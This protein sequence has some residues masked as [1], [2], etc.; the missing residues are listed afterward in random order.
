LAHS[1]QRSSRR[2]RRLAALA[3]L[4]ALA[5]CGGEE[6]RPD[7]PAPGRWQLA[8]EPGGDAEGAR[9]E[10]GQL[11][12]LGYASGTRPP[13]ERSG[14]ILH[15][16]ARAQPGANLYVSG[17]APEAVLMDMDGRALH[18][19]SKPY[20]EIWPGP[21]PG[22]HPEFAGFWRKARL[23]PGGE[24]LAIW[25][26][27]GLVKLDRDS[28]LL[29]ARAGGFHHDLDVAPDGSLVAL[30][31]E[32]RVRPELH[33]SEPVLEDFVAILDPQG[34]ERERISLLDCFLH[35]PFRGILEQRPL[36][37]GDVTHANAISLLD[38][39]RAGREPAFAAGS[40]LV[41]ATMLRTLAVVDLRRRRV[42]WAL[43]GEWE[44]IHDPSLLESGNLLLFHNGHAQRRSVVLELDPRAGTALWSYGGSAAQEFFT[45]CCGT[46]QR[47][48]NGNTLVTESENGRAFEVTPAGEVVWDFRSPHRAGERS[49][50]VATLFEL[51]R[52]PADLPLDWARVAPAAAAP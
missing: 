37:S 32:E 11:E 33:E 25:D 24:L 44:G 49:E 17:H 28:R 40:A 23:L 1:P 8:R 9:E 39:R 2:A 42:A 7:A 52:L 34:R 6:E 31:R 47:L 38:G 15:D 21:V 12:A 48:A 51:E 30:A 18:R 16:R 22:P 45:H 35:S 10:A 43:R 4:A 46:A 13:G 50:F 26:G 29:F 3:A 5:G 19:W 14:V 36:A 41:A 27:L 20:A